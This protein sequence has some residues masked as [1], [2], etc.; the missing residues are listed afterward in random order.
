M[1]ADEHE[2][3]KRA[4][5]LRITWLP[6][7]RKGPGVLSVTIVPGNMNDETHLAFQR[8]LSSLDE[9]KRLVGREG[10]PREVGH[11]LTLRYYGPSQG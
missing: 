2:G 9:M 10:D 5:S 11:V 4:T 3:V 1:A 8:L 7:T 6:P